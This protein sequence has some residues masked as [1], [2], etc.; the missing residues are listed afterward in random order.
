MKRKF[1]KLSRLFGVAMGAALF[2]SGAAKA[3]ECH[4]LGQ[5]RNEEKPQYWLCVGFAVED[6]IRP[7][8]RTRNN[9]DLIPIWVPGNPHA[10]QS[11]GVTS[12]HQLPDEYLDT[13]TGDRVNVRATLV[14]MKGD[15]YDIPHDEETHQLLDPFF[16]FKQAGIGYSSPLANTR[17]VR[18]FNWFVPNDVEDHG[19]TAIFYRV[20][21]DFVTPFPGIY[22]WI[23]EGTIQRRGQPAVTFTEKFVSS[24]P[25]IPYGPA[26]VHAHDID[27][28]TL[29]GAPEGWFDSVRP[30]NAPAVTSQPGQKSVVVKSSSPRFSEVMKR[31]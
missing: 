2:G 5:A 28:T 20:P 13:R 29:Q 17:Y 23:V 24:N 30:A 27:D 26:V 21:G 8:A 9:I 4:A 25:R 22:A 1:A 15:Y 12:Q 7:K 6:G 11:G 18:T 3:H 10:N 16:F 19:E 31:K 14:H